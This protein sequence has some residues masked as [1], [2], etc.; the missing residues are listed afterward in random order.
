MSTITEK[1]IRPEF[2]IYLHPV[3]PDDLCPEFRE[4]CGGWLSTVYLVDLN[5]H[6]HCCELTPSY[7][8][9]PLGFVPKVYPDDELAREAL[10]VELDEL[11]ADENVIYIHVHSLKTDRLLKRSK[12]INVTMREWRKLVADCGAP[13]R[14]AAYEECLEDVQEH[15]R[16]NPQW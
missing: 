3:S 16:G 1:E 11:L 2:R 13:G 14:E 12:S 6:V 8:C 7:E 4:R 5:R 15:L 10:Q 9:H